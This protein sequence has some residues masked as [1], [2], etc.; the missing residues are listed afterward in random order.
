MTYIHLTEKQTKVRQDF[1]T[2]TP[3][4]DAK[5]NGNILVKN[6]SWPDSSIHKAV[7]LWITFCSYSV[8]ILLRSVGRLV[9]MSFRVKESGNNQRRFYSGVHAE[10]A[11]SPCT[12]CLKWGVNVSYLFCFFPASSPWCERRMWFMVGDLYIF[13]SV[14]QC[15]RYIAFA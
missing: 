12:L 9:D 13:S 1:E 14:P 2:E 5:C 15:F 6:M 4:N 11:T 3:I 7:P 8:L 10:A